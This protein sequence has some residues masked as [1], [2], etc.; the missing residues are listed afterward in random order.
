[1]RLPQ[2]IQ[3]FLLAWTLWV[4]VQPTPAPFRAQDSRLSLEDQIQAKVAAHQLDAALELARQGVSQYPESSQMRQLLGV[5][6]FKKGDN[7]EARTA[8]RRAIELD[9]S[10]PENYFNLALVDLS[11]KRYAQAAASLEKDVRLD[12]RS[13][14]AHLLL[15]RAY[16]NLDLTAPAIEQFQKAIAL[17]PQLPLA[18][19]HLGYAYQSQ[20]NWQAALEEFKKE[21]EYNPNFYD[22]YW[23]AG[24]IELRRGDLDAAAELFGKGI[25]LNSQAWQ[26][27]YGLGRVLVA[28][29]QWPGAESELKKALE[30]SPDNIEVHYA[31][32]RLY[33]EAGHLDDA[34][35]EFNVC[36]RLNS[37]RQRAGTGIAGQ[38]P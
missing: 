1:M 17:Q 29:K 22:S 16:H 27:R 6:L 34:H 37:L 11:E 35:R 12:P 8:F 31:L 23:L 30:S 32:A 21:I 20:G 14:Y 9:S 4:G 33:Q 10:V 38:Q 15:G 26:A 19:Y 36:T 13:S 18:H 7:E 5:V 24:N 28:K 25:H 3:T 2:G